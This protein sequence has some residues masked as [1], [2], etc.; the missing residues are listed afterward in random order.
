MLT[1]HLKSFQKANAKKKMN[2]IKSL[3]DILPPSNEHT[4]LHLHYI[5]G[6]PVEKC[7]ECMGVSTRTAYRILNK[8]HDSILYLVNR[9]NRRLTDERS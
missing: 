1:E 6:I 7:G 9:K 3:I 4:L 8:G 5:D 2:I